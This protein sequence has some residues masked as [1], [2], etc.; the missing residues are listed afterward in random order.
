MRPV[1][2]FVLLFALAVVAAATLG[3]NDGLV[4]VYWNGWRTDVS[5]NLFMLLLLTACFL[6]ITTV[7]A[8]RALIGLP[9]RSRQ[10]RVARRDQ[11]A[12]AALRDALAQYLAGRY[13]RA[14]KSARR[15]LD[16]Q[17]KTPELAPDTEFSVLGHLLAAGSLH[18]LQ[19]RGER[20]AQLRRAL[21]LSRRSKGGSLAQEGAH[22]LAAEC[23]L[24]D[25]DAT[26]ALELLAELPPGVARRTQALRMKLQAARLARQ[27]QEA[28][29][30]ARLLAKHQGFSKDASVGLLRSLAFEVIDSARDAEQVHRLWKH[31]DTMDRR[32][33]F[34]AT[35]AAT[36][37][38]EHGAFDDGRALLR[39][40]WNR[41]SDFNV[42]ERDALAHGLVAC[43][44]G[45]GADWLPGL[46]AAMQTCPRQGAVAY[47]AGCAL[48]ERKLWGK[49]KPLL[50]QAADDEALTKPARRR[51]WRYLAQLA[52][53]QS[54]PERAARCYAAVAEQS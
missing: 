27:P 28:L 22:M 14:Q 16:I 48:A 40:F 49:A 11:I 20:D 23:A 4:S 47:A 26:R 10:W 38:A 31:L 37:L 43:V 53:E 32:D 42:E 46:E 29:K 1:I 2:W 36:R 12:Q 17:S 45:I 15:A 39:P 24:D 9:A 6:L 3:S 54:D 50:Q 13:G 5:F 19:D 21:E 30:T 51:A 35:R 7:Q 8:I 52:E 33:A 41:L 44:H 18:R 25:R 34:V